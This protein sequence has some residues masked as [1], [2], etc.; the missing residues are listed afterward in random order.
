MLPDLSHD[1]FEGFAVD[2]V[3]NVIISFIREGLL[4]LHELNNLKLNFDYSESD[5]GRKPQI[6]KTKPLNSQS[7]CEIR[8]LIRLLPLMIGTLVPHNHSSCNPFIPLE[9][10]QL[11][12][13][14]CGL[15]F[16]NVDLMLSQDKIDI[17]FP[18]FMDNFPDVS[19]KPRDI[20]FTII[21]L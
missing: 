19:M 9:F 6:I 7:V 3:S 8:T 21:L 1:L 11:V 13:M 10:A 2:V 20:F 15:K 18:K 17:L 16:N 5:K 12:K 4:E 14:L